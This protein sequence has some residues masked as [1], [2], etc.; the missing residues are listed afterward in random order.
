MGGDE[1]EGEGHLI[2]DIGLT[3]SVQKLKRVGDPIEP[4]E[5]KA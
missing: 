3:A 1:G 4:R 2:L 5:E